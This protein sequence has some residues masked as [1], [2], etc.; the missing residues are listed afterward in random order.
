MQYWSHVVDV[1]AA[2]FAVAVVSAM[3][4]KVCV[5]GSCCGFLG[6]FASDHKGITEQKPV[7]VGYESGPNVDLLRR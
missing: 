4:F 7:V 2:G 3:G 6:T 1:S 5:P